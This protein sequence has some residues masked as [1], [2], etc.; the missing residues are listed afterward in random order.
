MSRRAAGIETYGAEVTLLELPEPPSLEAGQVLIEVTAAGVANWDEIVRTGDWDV[1]GTPPLALG[2]EAAGEV[3]AVGPA[4][5]WPAV[6]TAVMTH[7]VPLLDQGCWAGRLVARADLLAEKPGNAS[8]AQA[9]AFPVPALTAEQVLSEALAVA[10][11]ETVLVHGAGGVTGGMIV[12]LAAYRGATV[13][14]TAGPARADRLKTLG[15]AEV[16]DYHDPEWPN[17]AIA[18]AGPSGIQAA[19]NAAPGGERAALSAVVDGGRLATITGAPPPVERDV[20]IADVYI[21][22]D[23]EQLRRLGAL[24]A[25]GRLHVDINASYPLARAAEALARALQGAGGGAVVLEP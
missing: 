5:D 14:A 1:G 24:V 13:I 16:L 15:A 20:S 23:G 19:A 22:A 3:I 11:G 9:A 25:D 8:W 17:R 12:E 4:V 21:R 7:P 2:V 10:P 18:A 6:G